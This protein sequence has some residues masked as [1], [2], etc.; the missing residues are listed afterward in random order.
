MKLQVLCVA[1][2]RSIELME[3]CISFLR[4]T[5]PNW[6][7]TIMYD[8]PVPK[9]IQDVMALFGD[10]R[11]H[12]THSETR[13]GLWGHPNR[14]TLL[15]ALKCD[16]EDFVL[17]T[18]DDNVYV[19]VF[20]NVMLGATK[21]SGIVMCDT[22]HSYTGYLPHVSELRECGIDMGAFIVRSDIAKEVGFN[23][24]HFSADGKY[25]EECGAKCKE[26]GL[27]IKHV[28]HLLFIHN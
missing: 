6:E 26:L 9:Q 5:N 19:P 10:E 11:I 21:D 24:T 22:L 18:N 17:L 7:L 3:L 14:K 16:S 27:E 12:F 23:H 1:Y 4:Q 15:E 8:G 28:R 13:N 25:A 2:G 20:V